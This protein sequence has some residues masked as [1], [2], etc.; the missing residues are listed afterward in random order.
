MA[1]AAPPE[2]PLTGCEARLAEVRFGGFV[3]IAEERE[4][5]SDVDQQC[6]NTTVFGM[7]VTWLPK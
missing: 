6:H 1:R 2:E 5:D 4:V 3:D 7:V